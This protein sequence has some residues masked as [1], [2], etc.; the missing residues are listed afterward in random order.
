MAQIR[1]TSKL[2][3]KGYKK[4]IDEMKRENKRFGGGLSGIASKLKAAFAVAVIIKFARA[5]GRAVGNLVQFGSKLSDMAA[6][7]GIAVDQFQRLQRAVRDA[8]GE[9]QHLVN[10]L[11]RLRDAQ[12]EVITGDKTMTD[13]FTALGLSAEDVVN[14]DIDQLFVSISKAL[15]DSGNAAEQFTAITDI[16]GQRNAPKLLE[17]MNAAAGGIEKLNDGLYTMSNE[18]A[19][20]LDI[21]ADKWANLGNNIKTR[22]ASGFAQLSR[23]LFGDEGINKRI[24]AAEKMKEL[25]LE[26]RRASL[27]KMKQKK[28]EAEA[29]E[30]I[31]NLKEQ[32]KEIDKQTQKY[33]EQVERIEET[34]KV[35]IDR[36]QFRRIG[37]FA[38]AGVSEQFRAA[39]QQLEVQKQ[40]EEYAKSLPKIEAKMDDVGRLV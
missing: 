33:K 7:T 8:G 5:L 2:D 38:G 29:E 17:A 11:T 6:Q 35:E 15:T 3:S 13:A 22:F 31:K 14:M 34:V 19:Q 25:E 16:I 32:Q 26:S 39:S 12:G 4:G 28:E 20:A 37:G 10:A 21:I 24:E 1:V 36:D 23:T 30:K 27:D 40:I 9:S 18:N